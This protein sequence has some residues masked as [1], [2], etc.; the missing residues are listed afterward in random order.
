M[1]G[2]N[3]TAI[4]LSGIEDIKV[5]FRNHI[6]K[7]FLSVEAGRPPPGNRS[8]TL[9][10][11]LSQLGGKIVILKIFSCITFYYHA[12]YSQTV[13]GED[14]PYC[15]AVFLMRNYRHVFEKL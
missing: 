4:R 14:L 3:K 1:I 12:K 15:K 9:L 13:C 5:D 7:F 8:K 6:L 10:A 11:Q 2:G